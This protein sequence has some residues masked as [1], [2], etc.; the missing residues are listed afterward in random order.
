MALAGSESMRRLPV[1]KHKCRLKLHRYLF[2]TQQ[3]IEYISKQINA[4]TIQL[5]KFVVRKSIMFYKEVAFS[6]VKHFV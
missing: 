5:K 2:C 4:Y 1:F 6:E 3:M